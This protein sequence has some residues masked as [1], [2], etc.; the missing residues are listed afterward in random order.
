M[1]VLAISPGEGFDAPRWSRVLASGV[2]AFMIREPRLEAAGLLRAA[3]WA[4]DR[5]PGVELWVNGRLD[6]ALAAGCGLHAGEAHPEVP[7]GLLPLSRPIH[8][9]AQIPG[10]A[11]AVQ[12]ILSPIF[13]VPGKG[14]P[15]GAARLGQVLDGMPEAPCRVLALGGIHPANAGAL[16]HPRLAGVA[17]IRGLWSKEDPR[18]VVEGLKGAWEGF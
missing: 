16:R 10:R 2:D 15:W 6:V 12:L 17:L 11:G 9:P 3:R 7:P 1:F 4:R 13:P 18:E 14:E 5:A 8:D